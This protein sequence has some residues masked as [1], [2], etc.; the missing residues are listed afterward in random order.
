[1]SNNKKVVIKKRIFIIGTDCLQNKLLSRTLSEE[2]GVASGVYEKPEMLTSSLLLKDG[3]NLLLIDGT[4]PEFKNVVDMTVQRLNKTGDRQIVALFNIEEDKKLQRDAVMSGI[5]GLFYRN[6]ELDLVKKGI[7]ALFDGD[8]WVSRD[9]L[10]DLVKNGDTITETT[11]QERD[12]LTSR[13]SEI[14]AM[15][16][17]GAT[18][19]EIGDKLNISPNTVKT[20]LYK[21]FKKI[22]VPNRMQAALWGAKNL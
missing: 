13:E 7:N 20:H 5:K 16:C 1:M 14:L 8:L 4:L 6:N 17:I 22:N 21:I 10:M 19:D 15:V 2:L 11:S 3:I 12:I 9:L 18:N